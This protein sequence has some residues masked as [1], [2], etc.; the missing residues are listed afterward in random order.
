[1]AVLCLGGFVPSFF[2]RPEFFAEPL[3]VWL[4]AHGVLMTSW[5]LIVITQ[6]WLIINGKAK[7]HRQL[8]YTAAI[9]A[10][11]AFFITYLTVAYLQAT[12]GHITGGPRMNIMLTSAFT[13][14]VACGIYYRRKPHV[15]KRLMVL[16]TAL[17]TVPGF[18]RLLRNLFQSSIPSFTVEKGQMVIM[19]FA[20]IFIG[21]MVYRDFREQRRPALG[22]VLSFACF[23]VGG[24]LGSIFMETEMWNSMVGSFASSAVP[25]TPLAH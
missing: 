24:T 4:N 10:L 23:F 20:V 19:V 9:V 13:C 7:M 1:M 17:L 25:G 3:P 22:T 15:H 8:G 6:A 5:Y 12:G 14:C 11:C 21:I 16:A 2:L 18:D